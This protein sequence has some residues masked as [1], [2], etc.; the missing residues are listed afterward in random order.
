MKYVVATALLLLAGCSSSPGGASR[1]PASSIDRVQ[2]PEPTTTQVIKDRI[3]RPVTMSV[4]VGSSLSE[5]RVAL[6]DQGLRVD[7]RRRARCIPGVVLEQAPAPGAKLAGGSTVRLVVAQAPAAATC[8]VPPGAG[9][10][11]ALRAWALGER[12]APPFADRVRLLV[13]NRVVRTLTAQEAAD[14]DEWILPI[15]YAER[16]D[17]RILEALAAGPMRTAAVPPHFCL[18]RGP[19]LPDD[20]L[21]RLPSSSLVTSGAE[22][23]ACMDVVA[24]QVW[25]DRGRITDVNV[26][27]GSP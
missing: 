17:V 19:V 4:L 16:V 11:R 7:V 2:P 8:I 21:S 23:R 5:V 18:G 3:G 26:L 20:L 24:V 14:P 12:W 27:M 13:A 1:H 25:A 15:A 9:G 10:A 6:R 22:V